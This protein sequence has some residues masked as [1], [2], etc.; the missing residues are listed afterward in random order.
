MCKALG[1]RQGALPSAIDSARKSIELIEFFRM[2][3]VMAKDEARKLSPAEQHERRRQ[4][5]RSH[6]RGRTHTP[7]AGE[8]GLSYTAVSKTTARFDSQGL[9]GLAPGTR[10]RRRGQDRA[11]SVEQEQ[12]SVA[13]RC[14]A[15]VKTYASW[16]S[17][18]GLALAHVHTCGF[19]SSMCERRYPAAL[20]CGS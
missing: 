8:V 18:A 19:F 7:I 11:L 2:S 14:V 9:A 6:K 5:I 15:L 1:E 17:A 20:G 16:S 12:K 4:V 13:V 10:G 3:P